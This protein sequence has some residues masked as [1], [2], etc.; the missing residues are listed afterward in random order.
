[1]GDPILHIELRRWA[2]L[3]LVAPCSANTLAKL[4][5]GICDDL[6]TSLLRALPPILA[7]PTSLPAIEAL[8]KS[9]PSPMVI[10]TP[11][12]K[13]AVQDIE[14]IATPSVDNGV[15]GGED[16]PPPTFSG[17]KGVQVW[18]FPAMNTFMYQHPL[19]ERHLS[20]VRSML[21]YRVVGPI[22]TF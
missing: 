8:E 21:K 6:T 18:V 9:E 15:L 13:E 1:M 19:T 4:A 5:G 12:Q 10:E 20:V 22:G 7:P 14:K 3:V 16:Q 2:D 17:T 11:S